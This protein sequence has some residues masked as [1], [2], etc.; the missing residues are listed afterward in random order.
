M[1][2]RPGSRPGLPDEKAEFTDADNKILAE[3][4]LQDFRERQKDPVRKELEKQWKQV[5]R[6]IALKPRPRQLRDPKRDKWKTNLEAS[7]QAFAL[8]ILRDDAERLLF[9]PGTDWYSAHAFAPEGYL[10]ELENLMAGMEDEGFLAGED[11]FRADQESAD[12]LIHAVLDTLHRQTMFTSRWGEMMGEAYRRGTFAGRW[13]MTETPKITN[14][15]RGVFLKNIKMPVLVPIPMKNLYLDHRSQFVL[16]EGMV[17]EPSFIRH[18]WQLTEDRKRA[19]KTGKGWVKAEAERLEEKGEGKKK[20]S[21]EIIEFEGDVWIPRSQGGLFLANQ[22]VRVALDAKGSPLVIRRM[23]SELPFRSYMVGIYQKDR[24]DSPYGTSPLLKGV[25]LQ[26]ILSEAMSRL[27]DSVILNADPPTEW[28]RDDTAIPAGPDLSP[29]GANAVDIP[30]SIRIIEGAGGNPGALL[31]VATEIRSWMQD[32]NSVNEPRRGS[33]PVSHTTAGAA[34]ISASRS[35][36]RTEVFVLNVERGPLQ[37]SLYQEYELVRS[38]KEKM[39][40]L[41]NAR[42]VRGHIKLRPSDLPEAADFIVHGSRGVLNKRER[43]ETMLNLTTLLANLAPLLA[44]LDPAAIPNFGEMIAKIFED[45]NIP[46]AERFKRR[47]E[48]QADVSEGGP[49]ISGAAEPPGGSDIPPTG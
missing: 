43:R 49:G 3:G 23:E 16:Q 27:T 24:I 29:G 20:G 41:L 9:P 10:V 18:F 40:V 4:I 46:D 30:N 47:P 32:L 12:L 2:P 17:I 38:I 42:G 36:L 26:L 1:P 48:D 8:E 6:Q 15:F 44:Q 7:E 5:D 35:I 33:S 14:D 25:P 31:A 34:D 21:T 37:T 19:M 13:V 28:A 39:P 22:V 45:H 11:G